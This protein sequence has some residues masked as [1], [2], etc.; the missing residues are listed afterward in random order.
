VGESKYRMP[1]T[2]LV[3]ED[4]NNIAELLLAFI[5]GEDNQVILAA[6]GIEGL[7]LAHSTSPALILCDRNMPGMNGDEL[8]RALRCDPATAKIPTVLM[9]GEPVA[10]LD[11]IRA[12]AFLP[13][14]FALDMVIE[15]VRRFTTEHENAACSH[16]RIAA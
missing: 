11:G 8:M 2:I 15:V 10:N 14:P 13:K 7:H 5:S 4:D 1:K 12:D 6:D 16:E 9:S 3:V